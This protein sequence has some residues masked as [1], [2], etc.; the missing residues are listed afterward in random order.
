MGVLDNMFGKAAYIRKL[1]EGQKQLD[2]HVREYLGNP[3][4]HGPND[5]PKKS[6]SLAEKGATP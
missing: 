2:K 5:P 3:G 6:K 1:E 4:V